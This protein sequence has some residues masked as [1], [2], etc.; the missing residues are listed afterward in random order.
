M[1]RFVIRLMTFLLLMFIIDRGVGLGMKYMQEHAR[2]GYIGHH[3]KI[4]NHT[5]E[6]ILIFGSSRAIHHYNP[7]TFKD[8]LGVSCYN[9]GQDGN[10]IILFYGWWQLM[11]DRHIPQ[12]VIYDVNPGF[13]LLLGESNQ[14]YLGWLRSEYDNNDIKQIFEKVDYTEKYKMYSMMYRYN[15]KF[16]QNIVDFIH[17]IFKIKSDGFL[18]LKGELDEMKIKNNKGETLQPKM[19]SLKIELIEKLIVDIKKHNA[20]IIFVASP[21]WYGKEDVQFDAL[22]KICEENGVLFLN[23]SNSPKYVRNNGYFRDGS[24]LNAR[25]ADEFTKDLIKDLLKGKVCQN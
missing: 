8:S 15:S 23:Y 20:Q 17:P 4:I 1:K 16:L 19:D 25:G 13:D 2:G 22:G 12:I 6:D 18:P 10:G 24:H 5:D 9:C 7:Q 3:N 21:V 14:K 11:K